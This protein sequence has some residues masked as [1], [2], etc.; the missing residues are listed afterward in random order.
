M[1]DS[2]VLNGQNEGPARVSNSKIYSTLSGFRTS[3]IYS[4]LSDFRTTTFAEL[5]HKYLI[6]WSC[7]K[8]GN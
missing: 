6:L 8:L 1:K 7:D 2:A 4:A 5:A 3:R